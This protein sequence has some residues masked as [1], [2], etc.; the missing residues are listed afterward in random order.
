MVTAIT[1]A[2]QIPRLSRESKAILGTYQ[3]WPQTKA[4]KD[5]ALLPSGDII[6]LN[7]EDYRD[8]NNKK[9]PDAIPLVWLEWLAGPDGYHSK[10]S[11]GEAVVIA[12]TG[13]KGS[14]KSETL[15]Y[16]TSKALAKDMPVWSNMG[17]KFYLVEPDGYIRLCQS[18]GL[19][20]G[21]V[22]LLSKELENGALVIDELSYYA[23]SRLSSS[24]RNRILNAAVNQVRKRTLDFYM[25]V[26]F[27]RQIDI[28]IREEL[29]CQ[30]SCEDVS[31]ELWAQ[32][33]ELDK[34]CFVR[35]Y[36]RDISGWSGHATGAIPGQ[37]PLGEPVYGNQGAK[38]LA[39]LRFTWPIYNSYDVVETADAFRKVR[40]DL[41]E[42]VIS[43]KQSI[44]EAKSLL[45]DTANAF[46]AEGE[47][48]P[49][50][51]T[52]RDTAAS[53]GVVLG[54]KALG[55]ALSKMGI[56]RKRTNKGNFYELKD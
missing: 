5:W 46:I 41:K 30:L 17:V 44:E 38:R 52:F 11:V 16:I 35:W 49:D 25:S 26:K 54:D 24:V 12:A 29:D 15:A 53:F 47:Y 2:I 36:A 19:D 10:L 21:A 32:K 48:M 55:L 1:E 22:L 6:R 28:N 13:L 50:T 18:N 8:P 7:C 37:D 42:T 56:K 9:Y 31:K 51:E 33:K 4:D 40:L 3:R 27:L 20:W 34:G 45:Q 39:R 14:G 23:S 43:D